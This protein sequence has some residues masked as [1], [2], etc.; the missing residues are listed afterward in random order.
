MKKSIHN[1]IVLAQLDKRLP[2]KTKVA[3]RELPP[4]AFVDDFA[5]STHRSV[6]KLDEG[7]EELLTCLE[8]AEVVVEDAIEI[9]N[10]QEYEIFINQTQDQQL[11]AIRIVGNDST[12]K[13]LVKT[14]ESAVDRFMGLDKYSDLIEEYESVSDRLVKSLPSKSITTLDDAAASIVEEMIRVKESGEQLLSP[15]P[16]PSWNKHIDG[17]IPGLIYTIGAASNS[18][19]SALAC[20]FSYEY[21]RRGKRILY[22][23]SESA[24]IRLFPRFTYIQSYIDEVPSFNRYKYLD[25]SDSCIEAVTNM[26]SR[27]SEA[28]GNRVHFLH[29]SNPVE[30]LSTVKKADEY[31][32]IM[33]DHLHNVSG[34]EE[35]AELQK[36]MVSLQ[37]VCSKYRRAVILFAQ[38]NKTL[39]G[40]ETKPTSNMIKGS[41][42]VL[43]CS[44][45]VA[46]LWYPNYKAYPN[47]LC[48]YTEKYR[49]FAPPQTAININFLKD[50][51][52]MLDEGEIPL[53]ALEEQ[54]EKQ[55]GKN[56][57][58]KQKDD[59]D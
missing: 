47:R 2:S 33:L 46:H 14:F 8:D 57:R 24:D 56:D 58:K 20:Y 19:K 21:A 37:K 52:V 30:I 43:H 53:S 6:L 1:I 34:V 51:Q 25:T 9:I 50:K 4:K 49:E 17:I 31:D 55:G 5:I 7:K 22:I 54:D 13:D 45:V 12:R 29:T 35:V 16:F 48:M 26:S 23:S 38:Y 27:V 28:T 32:I 3:I 44:D 11:E 59:E 15:T 40:K 36:F 39:A 10:S 41:G 18:G 42:A